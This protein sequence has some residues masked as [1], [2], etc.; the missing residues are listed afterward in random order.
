MHYQ[1]HQIIHCMTVN[2]YLALINNKIDNRTLYINITH[3]MYITNSSSLMKDNIKE[4]LPGVTGGI[5]Q[6]LIGHPFDTI[7]VKMVYEKNGV[8]QCIKN[9]YQQNGLGAFYRGLT[10]PLLGCVFLNSLAFYTFNCTNNYINN[11]T[12][13]HTSNHTNNIANNLTNN[14]INNLISGCMAGTMTSFFEC[15]IDYIKSQM[16]SHHNKNYKNLFKTINLNKLYRG[17]FAT[18]VRN[19]PSMGLFFSSFQ[20]TNN[21]LNQ[22][23][24]SNEYINAFI[25]GGV[26]GFARWGITYPF[27]FYKTKI[28]TCDYKMTYL[29]CIKK[30]KFKEVWKGY[31]PCIIRAFPVNSFLFLAV[32][33]TKKL[34]SVKR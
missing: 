14:H 24:K 17:Y 5:V 6:S 9:S 21:K 25:A 34:I 13:N 8:L 16:Q 7:K 19:I 31:I 18:L 11:L 27:D 1:E 29:E 26:S 15:P 32:T 28:Q 4:I 30:Y 10:P 33:Y 2:L 22:L 23:N 3:K 20:Y 12:N